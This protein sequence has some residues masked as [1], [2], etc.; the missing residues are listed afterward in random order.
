MYYLQTFPYKDL[1]FLFR[2]H[3]GLGRLSQRINEKVRP[4]DVVLNLRA[5][6]VTTH[7][8]SLSWGPPIRLT[9]INYKISYNAYK[10]FVDA[11]VFLRQFSA[12]LRQL[13]PLFFLLGKGFLSTFLSSIFFFV[14]LN[15]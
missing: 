11:Q 13:V 8:M 5:Q 9:P 7:T 3:D 2:T 1:N 10:E 14:N 12:I 15:V 6:A 4:Q